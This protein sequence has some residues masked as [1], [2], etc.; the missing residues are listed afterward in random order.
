MFA[1]VPS[2]VAASCRGGS[3]R[4]GGSRTLDRGKEPPA[5][6]GG[7]QVKRQGDKRKAR[8]KSKR[9]ALTARRLSPIILVGLTVRKLI[10]ATT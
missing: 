1:C 4:V 6:A 9:Q 10:V 3:S 5:A 7:S 8:T 2:T